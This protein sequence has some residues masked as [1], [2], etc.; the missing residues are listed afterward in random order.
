VIPQ[1]VVVVGAGIAGLVAA[2]ELLRGGH[3]RQILEARM[4][5]GSRI[6]TVREPFTDNLHAEAG[7]IDIGDGYSLV[8]RYLREF[9][10]RSL[11]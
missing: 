8:L 7:A 6:Y 3:D 10:W 9:N 1:K 4:R 5:P 11:T 2:Y